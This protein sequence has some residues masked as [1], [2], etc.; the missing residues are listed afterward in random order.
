MVHFEK[1]CLS[2]G[3]KVIA[4]FDASTP[5]ASVNLLY[6]VGSRD[7]DPCCT[8]LAHLFEHLMFEGSLNIADFDR[9]LQYAGG[10]NNAFT[11]NDITNYYIT[12]PAQNI[13]TAFWLES[14]RMLGLDLSEEKLAI[15][16]KVVVEEFKETHLNQPYGDTW[17]HLRP[18]AY[19][20]HPY[21]WSTIGKETAHIEQVDMQTVKA[22]FASH[23]NP[24][25]AILTVAGNVK[26][27]TVFAL[28]EKWFGDIPAGSPKVRSLTEEPG[29][30][31]ARRLVLER[32][33]PFNRLF[34]AF[35]TSGRMH[36]DFY[37]TDILS[38]ILGSG[39]S[40]RLEQA[41]VKNQKLFSD[42]QAYVTASIDPGLFVIEGK[43]NDA[44][45][46]QMAEKAIWEQLGAL[47]SET[48]T[49]HEL[50]KVKNMV[51][52]SYVFSENGIV[53]RSLSL[54]YFELLGNASLLNTQIE[55]Y[56]S[57]S[58]DALRIAAGKI[59][60]PSKVSVLEYRASKNGHLDD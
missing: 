52:A 22:F 23:Y 54:S 58:G 3:L 56:L 59:F 42:I 47:T 39:G 5:L 55:Q 41:L 20:R 29:Q 28:A 6:D 16:K 8:G 17:L 31:S 33:V 15:Q 18:M 2:N 51:E 44:I 13:E 12:L 19:T 50:Q 36:P 27:D 21:S 25:N 4:Q 1:A 11:T 40:S 35:K 43:L 60:D 37:S 7:E 53:A 57:V 14:D 49:D 48:L 46:F 24:S 26:P 38:D 9:N 34:M 30:T 45:T 10:E 32:P